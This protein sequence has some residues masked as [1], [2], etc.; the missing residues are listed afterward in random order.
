MSE[1]L[2]GQSWYR[3]A[4]LRPRLRRQAR[5]HRHRVRGQT[6][7]VLEQPGR[8]RSFRLTPVQYAV[9]ALMDGRR[10]LDEIWHL[11]G[12]R[13]GDAAP[14]QDQTIQLLDRL[15]EADLLLSGKR[16]GV[17]SL[18][19]RRRR[20]DRGKRLRRWLEPLC[21]RLPLVNPSR[22]LESLE[23]LA[24]LL[25]SRGAA[26]LWGLVA[27][28]A[29]PVVFTHSTE[30][31]SGALDRL[32]G[33]SRWLSLA[34]VFVPLKILHEMGHLLALRARG[35]TAREVGLLFIAFVP[36]PYVDASAASAFPRR[37]DRLLVSAAGML[38]ELFVAALALLA[39]S[40]LEPGALRALLHD[41]IVVSSITTILFNLNPLLRFDGYYL[42]TDALQLPNLAP[43][44]R[45][46]WGALFHRLLTGVRSPGPVDALP[47]E[48][49]W[50]L[51]Y[52]PL[53]LAYRMLVVVTIVL[54]VR[55]S[56][57]PVGELLAFWA[58]L[59]LLGG[60]LVR[61]SRHL[62][63]SGELEGH[64]PRA[65]AV[66]TGLVLLVGALVALVP[67]PHWT[68]V[69]GVVVAVEEAGVRTEVEGVVER[70]LV[71]PGDR[72]RR[73]QPLV[74]CLD[75]EL[76]SA[77]KGLEAEVREY[78]ARLARCRDRD[79]VLAGILEEE[80]NLRRGRLERRRELLEARISRSQ[81]EGVFVIADAGDL[82]GRF[83]EAGELIG[84]VLRPG[85][86]RVRVALP[87]SRIDEVRRDTRAVELRLLE[88][89]HR[90]RPAVIDREL[91]GAS[92]WLP[93]A[94]LG[95]TG[96]GSIPV[97][98]AE[99]SGTRALEARFQ[100]ELRFEPPSGSLRV[101]GR[102]RV[103]FE[104]GWKPLAWRWARDLER[105]FPGRIHA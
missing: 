47:G 14:T 52:A 82:P 19:E 64:R 5:W 43:R 53:S 48:R 68:V 83:L 62:L 16:S 7:H 87:Q 20:E 11:A 10:T 57:G 88:S 101:G 70:L 45:R 51:L 94:A 93:S 105:L 55:E 17:A 86:L 59:G 61:G 31:T 103:R 76:E 6:L 73:D 40:C 34:L 58:I 60:A 66:T 74:E 39:W 23:P 54:L 97:D 72:V 84:H 49:K 77:V 89:P 12:E 50:L 96:G 21:W 44:S 30:L 100:V 81:S 35:A 79:P 9:V 95:V 24:R 25:F 3:V 42:F 18:L 90:T 46:F 80:L 8:G 29:L 26:A 36:L 1:G 32:L 78:E 99:P 38:F 56:L 67:L 104:H 2:H 91:P 63:R 102:A 85:D 37:R 75:P 71:A 69:E 92:P 28:L 22:W 4:H 27:L 13:L 65:L 41:V 98:P 33:P 15:H